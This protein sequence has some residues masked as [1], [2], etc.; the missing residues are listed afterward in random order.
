MTYKQYHNLLKAGA[1]HREWMEKHEWLWK[2]H[3]D[4]ELI[5]GNQKMMIERAYYY[6]SGGHKHLFTEHE[7]LTD[8]LFKD[9]LDG[10]VNEN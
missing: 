5:C 1:I 10:I 6:L 4:G 9:V 2:Y 7:L 3:N 8:H